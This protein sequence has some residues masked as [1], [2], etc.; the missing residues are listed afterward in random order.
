[1]VALARRKC[2]K[3]GLNRQVPKYISP[4]GRICK[5]CQKKNRSA[6]VH[7][8]RVAET[9]NWPKGLS[10]TRLYD[11]QGGVC[12]ICRAKPRYRMDVDH[13]HESGWV[14]G[15]LCRRCNRQ[16]L[17]V[18]RNQPWILRNAADYL[19]SPPAWG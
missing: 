18:A 9:Y 19:D 4:K 5:P 3:C 1:M 11:L 13:D 10:Y 7:Q 15:L 14:R 6:V 2:Q 17:F 8:K 12:A 16:L